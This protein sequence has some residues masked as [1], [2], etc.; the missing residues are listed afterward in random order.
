MNENQIYRELGQRTGNAVLIGVT[1]PVRTGK[2]TFVKRFMEE[3]VLPHI[4][5]AYRAER[6]RDE[7]P[8]SGSGRT[9]MTTEPKFVPEE[10]VT[11]CPD[12]VTQLSVRLI[13]SVGYMIPGVLGA[14]EDGN[15]RM[16]TTPWFDEEIP[17][18][19]AAE[20]GTKKVMEEHS[21]VGVIVT[22]DGSITDVPRGDYAEAE[23]RAIADMQA[24][25]KPFI[26]LVNSADPAGQPAQELCNTIHGQTG[27]S[28]M[29]VDCQKMTEG[30][31]GQILSALLL[32]F[33]AAEL[34]VYMPGWLVSLPEEHP[35]KSGLYDALRKTADEIGKLSEAEPAVRALLENET[36]SGC[37]ITKLD[38]STG[39]VSI[40][41]DFPE[42]LFYQTLSEVCGLELHSDGD[43]IAM[44]T[45]MANVKSRCERI[46]GALEQALATGY[47]IAMPAGDEIELEAPEV[48]KKGGSFAVKLKAKAPS[49]HMIRADL[50]SEV[51][52]IVGTQ[53]QTEEFGEYLRKAYDEDPKT[54][55]ETNIF[56]KPLREFVNEDL[57]GRVLRMPETVRPKFRRTLQRIMNEGSGGLICIIL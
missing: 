12:E 15:P 40:T 18:T 49:I 31:I 45:D 33:P 30:E 10:A 46:S 26:V 9:I 56:G 53:K 42:A 27:A 1:G 24:T 41:L 13:D 7:L 23:R 14:D 48:V 57:A 50:E 35:L 36:L 5:D 21:T 19:Q 6:A 2:S 44:L 54:V 52:P 20:L 4:D 22:T 25:G 34:R 28:V 16:V 39:T 29:A 38:P 47:G 32:E 11:I 51:S 55:W 43:L 37:S 3:L 17:M 8:Q